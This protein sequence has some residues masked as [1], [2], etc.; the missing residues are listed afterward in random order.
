[1]KSN[2]FQ[3]NRRAVIAGGVGIVLILVVVAYGALSGGGGSTPPVGAPPVTATTIGAGPSGSPGTIPGV[4]PSAQVYTSKD[5]FTPLASTSTS[6]T[7]PA[8]STSSTTAAPAGSASSGQAPGGSGT[9]TGS[10]GTSATTTTVPPPGGNAGA[11]GAGTGTGTSTSPT[12]GQPVELED[13]YATGSRTYASITVDDSLYQVTIDQTFAGNY[14]V[15][16]L[17][18]S[19]QCGDF[20]HGGVPF[21]LCKGQQV[22]K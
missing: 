12:R 20:T 9:G 15:V 17:S 21:H 11:S 16:D 7:T 18:L 4:P 1:M 8:S 6:T 10:S 5:P 19:T 2:L 13:V 14:T 3:E 22:L